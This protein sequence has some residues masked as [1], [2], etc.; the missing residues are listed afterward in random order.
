MAILLNC[1]N[2]FFGRKF[3]RV[4]CGERGVT[5]RPRHYGY[6]RGSICT[7]QERS[8]CFNSAR[9]TTA[10]WLVC[11]RER[12]RS[13]L[14]SQEHDGYH[15]ANASASRP[16]LNIGGVSQLCFFALKQA[17]ISLLSK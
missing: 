16:S 4:Y 12:S 5:K 3:Q 6:K 8:L 1:S 2:R 15:R 17:T 13:L 10:R 14:Q 7:E 9:S 11:S